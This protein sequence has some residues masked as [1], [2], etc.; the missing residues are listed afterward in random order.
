MME[1]STHNTDLNKKSGSS[2]DLSN[3]ADESLN[4]EA[5]ASGTTLSLEE[6]IEEL[7]SALAEQKSLVEEYKDKHIRAIAEMDNMRKRMERE[8]TELLKYGHEGVLKSL[9]PVLDGFDRAVS[10]Q[11]NETDTEAKKILDGMVMVHKQLTDA[12]E[13]FGL[14]S[15]PSLNQPFDPNLHQ[16][17]RRIE[18]DDVEL[19]TIVEEFAKGYTLHDR[20]LRPAMVSVAVPA[21]SGN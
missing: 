6:K 14:V 7:Q 2:E 11:A 20:L 21:G 15:I 12:L 1:N 13:K 3:H 19:D 5:F 16:A 17:V 8:R 9:L 18:S 4:H 10:L